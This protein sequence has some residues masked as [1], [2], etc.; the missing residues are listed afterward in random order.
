MKKSVFKVDHSTNNFKLYDADD[1]L[2]YSASWFLEFGKTT[3]E[4]YNLEKEVIFSIVKKFK[5]W[6]WRIAYE[7]QNKQHKTFVL[8]SVNK[9]NTHFL[10]QFKEDVYEIKIHY[11]QKKSIF[12]NGIKIAEI[13]DA[14]LSSKEENT[15]N[16]LLVNMEDVE[17]IFLLFCC[18]KTG[19]T[20]QKPVL[21]SQ[22]E[23]IPIEEKWT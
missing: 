23:L 19:E 7:I 17:M 3:S 20:N 9:E 10:L 16:L 15:S 21:K 18:L 11:A 4:I 13:D 22:K 12:K 6:K 2:Y 1:K 5:F 8:N 14:F